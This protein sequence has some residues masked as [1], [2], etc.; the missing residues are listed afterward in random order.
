[1]IALKN[2]A[3]AAARRVMTVTAVIAAT[4]GVGMLGILGAA[5]RPAMAAPEPS[6]IPKRWQL[7]ISTSLLRTAVVNIGGT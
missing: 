1:M 2:R 4:A 3:R 6:P 7:E 5:P